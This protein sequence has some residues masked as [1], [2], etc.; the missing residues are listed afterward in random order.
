MTTHTRCCSDP[1]RNFSRTVVV[2]LKNS[3]WN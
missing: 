3:F 2:V 1:A